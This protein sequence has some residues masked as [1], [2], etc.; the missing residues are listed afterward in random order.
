MLMVVIAFTHSFIYLLQ[1]QED[2]FFQDSFAVDPDGLGLAANADS[3]SNP[4]VNVFRAFSVLWFFLFGVWDP[5]VEGDVGDDTM[6]IILSILFSFITVVIFLNIVIAIMS[7]TVE[8]MT[9]EGNSVWLSHFAAVLSE[10][11]MLW[12]FESQR[13]NRKNNPNFIYY[14]GSKKDIVRQSALMEQET[15]ELLIEMEKK[16]NK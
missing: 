13:H 11:E 4:F 16:R 5:I 6:T 7:N 2:G 14:F 3:A 12:C 15:E 10:I 1:D 9:E 8:K